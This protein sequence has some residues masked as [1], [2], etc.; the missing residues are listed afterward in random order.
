M[1]NVLRLLY[2][3]CFVFS[4]HAKQHKIEITSKSFIADDT[5]KTTEFI[6]HVKVK[7]GSDAIEC[8]RLLVTLNNKNKPILY[9]AVGHVK[10][11]L[12]VENGNRYKGSAYKM[13][14][15]SQK[16]E[17][18]L[19]GNARIL[20][21]NTER[22]LQGEKIL[23]NQLTGKVEVFGRDDKPVKFIFSVDDQ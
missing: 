1:K 9:R 8:E 20:E 11:L 12:S 14:Y 13:T 7:K 21:I 16:S 5:K 15:D 4:L 17:Y 2:I 23:L 18:A 10:F 22:E 19:I 3:I 6:G